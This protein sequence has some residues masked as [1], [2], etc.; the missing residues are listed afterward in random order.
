[1]RFDFNDVKINAPSLSDL[2]TKTPLNAKILDVSETTNNGKTRLEIAQIVYLPDGREVPFTTRISENQ[3]WL[4]AAYLNAL[5]EV[6]DDDQLKTL[7]NLD[8]SAPGL[9]P[10]MAGQPVILEFVRKPFTNAEGVTR[11]YTNVNR[12]SRSEAP[13][14]ESVDEN[15]LDELDDDLPVT[16]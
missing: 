14:L 3:N 4:M 7:S 15:A 2:P 8:F 12:V 6:E 9:R 10:I 16:I 5:G 1:M 13:E 11:E